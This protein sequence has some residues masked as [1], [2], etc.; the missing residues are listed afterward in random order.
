[1]TYIY[2]TAVMSHTV[3]YRFIIQTNTTLE[4]VTFTVVI[5]CY[6]YQLFYSAIIRQEHKYIIGDVCYVRGLSFTITVLIYINYPIYIFYILNQGNYGE[7]SSIA[8]FSNYVLVFLP[9]DG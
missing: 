9:H 6:M 1:M 8:Y 5:F 4:H 7:A 3:Q 2:S